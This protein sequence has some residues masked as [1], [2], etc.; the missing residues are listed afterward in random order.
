[1]KIIIPIVVLFLI[2]IS[3]CYYDSQEFLYPQLGSPCDTTNI[4]FSSSV[5]PILDQ[6]CLS[7]HGNGTATSYGGGIKLENYSDIKIRVDDGKLIGS[8]KRSSGFSPMPKGSS[9]LESCKITIIEKWINAG[10]PNN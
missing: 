4:T 6:S 9:Q 1:M 7:C 10:S 5:F 2:A 8:I 3:S